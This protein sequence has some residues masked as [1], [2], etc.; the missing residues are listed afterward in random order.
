M[1]ELIVEK[2]KKAEL[3]DVIVQLEKSLEDLEA[4]RVK[5]VL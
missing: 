5:R 3:D 2:K 4:G 1:A